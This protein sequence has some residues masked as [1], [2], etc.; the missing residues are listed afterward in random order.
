MSIQNIPNNIIQQPNIVIN[1]V[2]L[3]HAIMTNVNATNGIPIATALT[4]APTAV[5]QSGEIKTG[6]VVETIP[7][8]GAGIVGVPSVP[9]QNASPIKNTQLTTNTDGVSQVLTKTRLNDLVR[10]TDPTLTLE[11]EVEEALL[12]YTDDFLDRVLNGAAMIAKHRHVNT[13]EV[14]DVQQ[15]LNRNYGIWAPG[16]GTDE[17]RPYKRSMTAESHKQRLALIRKALKKY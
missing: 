8:A 2:P 4:H 9:V 7:I 11:D 17:L 3:S 14:K 6:I 10:D 13:I 1:Q 15:F 5:D 16:F 12:A